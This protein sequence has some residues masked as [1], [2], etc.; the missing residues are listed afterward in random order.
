[1]PERQFLFA[2]VFGF[3]KVVLEIFSELDA[4]KREVPILPGRTQSPKEARRGPMGWPHHRVARPALWPRRQVV[5]GTRISTDIAPLPI[6]SHPQEKRKDQRK[7]HETF[8]SRRHRQ[9]Y[10]GR[11]LKLFP[12]PCR[13]GE[14]SPE[15]SSSPCLHSG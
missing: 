14:S 5:W 3:R 8:C 7:F 2:A 4:A 12:A 1:M 10:F 11:V 6:Y 13:R 15:A 9:P